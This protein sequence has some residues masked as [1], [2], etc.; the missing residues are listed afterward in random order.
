MYF[1][2][3]LGSATPGASDLVT[4]LAPSYGVPPQLALAVANQE[5]GFNQAAVSPAGA[6]GVMQ[7]MPG[8]AAD[9]GVNPTDLTG[10]VQGG[11]TYLSQMFQKFGNWFDALSAYN[12]GPGNLKAGQG[13]ASS[14]LA[15]AGPLDSSSPSGSPSAGL[16]PDL[17]SSS[18]GLDL[19]ALP[20]GS[21]GLS[22]TAWAAIGLGLAG[23][24]WWATA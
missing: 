4:S 3:G 5:S 7:L 22:A 11:L 19:S 9:L 18:A 20:G 24:I 12:A 2:R 21:A 10:N 23:L 17:S 6:I 16:S 13:Y 14:V 15:A 1:S 8:T